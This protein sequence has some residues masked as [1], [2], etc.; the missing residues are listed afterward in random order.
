MRSITIN[1]VDFHVCG[2]VDPKTGLKACSGKCPYCYVDMVKKSNP[3]FKEL[4][5]FGD[6]ATLMQ[7]IRNIRKSARPKD[8]VFVGGDPCEH[9]NLMELI[10]LAKGLGMN[11]AVLSNT[12]VY[13]M[14]GRVIPIEWVTPFVDE[15]AFT[16]H[17]IGDRH[18]SV[19]GNIGA[20]RNGMWQL[21]KFMFARGTTDKAVSILMNFVPYTM[22][23]LEEMMIGVIEE[24]QMDPERDYFAIQRIAPTGLAKNDYERWKVR[25]DLLPG[26][27]R[28]LKDIRERLGFETKLDTIDVFPWCSIPEE[29]HD[30]LHEGGC[31]W[32]QPNGVLS[33]VQDGG[34]Q[35]C[36]LSERT[37]GSFLEIDTREKFTRFMLD[38]PTLRAFREHR[39]LED[40][41][42]RC[43][44]LDRCGGGCVIAVG[45]EDGDPY[46]VDGGVVCT[47]RDYLAL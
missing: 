8:F 40:R 22:R 5:V 35:R 34:I 29:Y 30:M 37:I 36:A 33:V 46:A 11:V 42:L 45:G 1:E 21:K 4:P 43:E 13:K 26:A 6:K 10:K 25:R 38:N 28:T 27:L 14:D 7:A 41:C 2:G 39:H 9:D 20:Y 24:L 16:L 32:G 3:V 19:N 31:Q 44:Y 17:G 12:H 18:D 15:L 47:G 23:H